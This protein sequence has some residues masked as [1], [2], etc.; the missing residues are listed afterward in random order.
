MEQHRSRR[1][2]GQGSLLVKA[3]LPREGEGRAGAAHTRSSCS[4]NARVMFAT[5]SFMYFLLYN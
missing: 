5:A 1:E 2:S 4:A 3:F